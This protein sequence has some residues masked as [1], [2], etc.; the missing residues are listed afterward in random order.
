MQS[1]DGLPNIH[2]MRNAYISEC[3]MQ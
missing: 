2:V 3:T 1:V